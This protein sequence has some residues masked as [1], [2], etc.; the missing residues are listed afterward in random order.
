MI[1]PRA[2]AAQQGATA[3][4]LGEDFADRRAVVFG[5]VRPETG[6][7]GIGHGKRLMVGS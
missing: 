7:M 5:D 6:P 2:A 1:T 4:E 3:D